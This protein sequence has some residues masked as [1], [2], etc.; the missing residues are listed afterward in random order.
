MSKKTTLVIGSEGHS[1][2]EKCIKWGDE[3][4]YIG[5]F[6]NVIINLSSLDEESLKNILKNDLLYFDTIRRAIVDVQSKKP[7]VVFCILS[8]YL[9]SHQRSASSLADN[10][11]ESTNNYSWSPVIPILEKIPIAQV[12][13]RSQSKMPRKYLDKIKNYNL[14]YNGYI[15][16]T[17]YPNMDQRNGDTLKMNLQIILVNDIGRPAAFGLSWKIQ[18]SHGSVKSLSQIPMVFYPPTE[19]PKEGIDVLLDI[20]S[21]DQGS[22]VPEW[23]QEITLPGEGDIVK[24]IESKNTEIDLLMQDVANLRMDLSKKDL[25]KKLLYSQGG[26]LESI[27][28]D[29]FKFLGINLQKPAV[30]NVEDRFFETSDK[31]IIYFEIRGVNRLMNETDL[32]QLIQR[33]A[34]KPKSDLYKTRG[35]FVFNHQNTTN[36]AD[37]ESAFHHNIINKAETFGICLI[38]CKTLFNLVGKKLEGEAL[39]NFDQNIF[40]VSGVF[41]MDKLK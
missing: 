3:L 41:D 8:D 22:V 19:D 4:V 34:D 7:L 40:N 26:E 29:S 23:L 6:D 38:D 16:A 37:R 39:S 2:A 36:P 17:G 30:S 5:D 33:I 25:F 11:Q 31:Q 28:T 20:F 18:G 12:L 35:V 1:K 27:V 24:K 10:L 13:D 21:G 9:F 15:N 32:G 14:L